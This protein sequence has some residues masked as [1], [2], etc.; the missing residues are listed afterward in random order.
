MAYN[1]WVAQWRSARCY[2]DDTPKFKR[3]PK[4]FKSNSFF[5]IQCQHHRRRS[6][7]TE[8]VQVCL[9]LLTSKFTERAATWAN[10]K[11]STVRTFQPEK[12]SFQKSFRFE[13]ALL[14]VQ[15]RSSTVPLRETSSQSITILHY[16]AVEMHIVVVNGP[17]GEHLSVR[18]PHQTSISLQMA[19]LFAHVAFWSF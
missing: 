8:R 17:G 12:F 2:R 11:C 10:L 15:I 6:G 13:S 19:S 16:F 3:N 5:I 9:E 7:R 4:R 14:A 1:H 18:A